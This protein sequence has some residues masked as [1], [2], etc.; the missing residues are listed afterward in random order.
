MVEPRT[1]RKILKGPN[2]I[3]TMKPLFY[4]DVSTKKKIKVQN[5]NSHIEISQSNT[6]S[7][8]I[9]MKSSGPV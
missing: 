5:K 7:D 1:K 6:Y 8:E 4:F 9:L 3:D 2:I